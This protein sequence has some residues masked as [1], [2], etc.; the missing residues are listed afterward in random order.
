MTRIKLLRVIRG[1]KIILLPP[2]NDEDWESCGIIILSSISVRRQKH[3]EKEYVAF[4]T[5]SKFPVWYLKIGATISL[6]YC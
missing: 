5:D 3:F 6:V 2:G 1:Q 4:P